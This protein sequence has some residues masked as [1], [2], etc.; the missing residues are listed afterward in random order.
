MPAA[1]RLGAFASAVNAESKVNSLTA[2]SGVRF[3]MTGAK[4]EKPSPVPMPLDPE[5]AAARNRSISKTRGLQGHLATI[6]T[7]PL[8]ALG[9]PTIRVARNLGGGTGA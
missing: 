6:L 3:S 1:L 5:V 4:A 7:G 8:G 9:E 2:P